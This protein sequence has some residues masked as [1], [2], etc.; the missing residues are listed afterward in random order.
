MARP[1]GSKSKNAILDAVE[2][3]IAKQGVNAISLH[4]I[5]VAANLSQ[6]TIYY[7]YETKDDIIFDIIVKHIDALKQEYIE[8]L[9]RH[10]HDLTSDR[11]FDVLFYK[12]VKL[13]NR[14]KMH[15][16]L[17]NECMSENDALRKKFLEKYREWQDA[18]LMGVKRVFATHP[19]PEAIAYLTLLLLD[20]MIVQ[21][22]LGAP[23]FDQ[24]RLV[25]VMKHLGGHL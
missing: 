9:A 24:S 5:A 3:L 13:F 20:G 18:L 6:G 14:A 21:E 4:D 10:E 2:T 7:H 12:G 16:F 22:V 11:F 23:I 15:L 1:V 19:D 25:N 8:W 17:I